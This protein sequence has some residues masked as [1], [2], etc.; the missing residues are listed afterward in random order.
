MWYSSDLANPKS[1]K[2][3]TPGFTDAEREEFTNL[4]TEGFVDSFRELY[5]EEKSKYSFWTFMGNCRAKNVGWLVF[6]MLSILFF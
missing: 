4:L 1:N 2:N 6:F 3:K 5:P